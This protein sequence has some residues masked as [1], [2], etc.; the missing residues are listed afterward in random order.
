MDGSG[1]EE[2]STGSFFLLLLDRLLFCGRCFAFGILLVYK[3]ALLVEGNKM[4]RNRGAM[5]VK[6]KSSCSRGPCRSTGEK[7]RR[8]KWVQD[9]GLCAKKTRGR[10]IL[11]FYLSWNAP[12]TL[13]LRKYNHNSRKHAESCCCCFA[14][15]LQSKEYSCF[16]FTFRL[17]NE[18]RRVER[19]G[20]SSTSSSRF[21]FANLCPYIVYRDSSA[22]TISYTDAILRELCNE[23]SCCT[24]CN[25]EDEEIY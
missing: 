13:S 18:M 5:I 21:S 6:Y 16:R 8:R 17:L 22:I 20:N 23:I 12:R 2:E 4:R 7:R 10:K 14:T 3:T 19:C 24:S 11:R 15:E 9:S 1:A 25:T